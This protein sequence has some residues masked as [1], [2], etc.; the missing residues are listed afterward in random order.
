MVIF[1]SQRG[2]V[3]KE[4]WETLAY[5]NGEA[6]GKCISCTSCTRLAHMLEHVYSRPARLSRSFGMHETY[7]S[8]ITVV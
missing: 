1:Q 7:F 3:S 8:G 5:M 6:V 4:V 2:S